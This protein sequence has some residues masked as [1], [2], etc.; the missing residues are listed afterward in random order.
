MNG[1]E[2]AGELLR[3]DH[4]SGD[5]NYDTLNGRGTQYRQ[6]Y[7]ETD[8]WVLHPLALSVLMLWLQPIV[9]PEQS[10]Q[11][12]RVREQ[13]GLIAARGSNEQ[14]DLRDFLKITVWMRCDDFKRHLEDMDK[15]KDK[16]R[17]GL[18]RRPYQHLHYTK[19]NGWLLRPYL[20]AWTLLRSQWENLEDG[21]MFVCGHEYVSLVK[22]GLMKLALVGSCLLS[23]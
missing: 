1:S 22:A 13:P 12:L 3:P 6:L 17:N 21:G 2:M 8:K 15:D 20:L 18:T 4:T 16:D 14:S 23:W 10:R 11:G 5:G 7:E 9:G 19:N